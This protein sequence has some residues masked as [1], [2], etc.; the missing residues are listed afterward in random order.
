M[1]ETHSIASIHDLRTVIRGSDRSTNLLFSVAEDAALD[2]SRR[3]WEAVS[4]ASGHGRLDNLD[5]LIG[6][7]DA[8]RLVVG[9]LLQ[10]RAWSKFVGDQLQEVEEGIKLVE[11]RMEGAGPGLP[12]GFKS[13][14][15]IGPDLYL[16]TDILEDIKVSEITS[17]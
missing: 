14:K 12:R 17:T 8:R 1:E 6:K 16:D 5:I 3:I 13:T 15:L 7:E 9:R 4:M 2:D 10:V 11:S